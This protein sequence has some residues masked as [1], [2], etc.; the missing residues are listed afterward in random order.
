MLELSFI[1]AEE[2]KKSWKQPGSETWSIKVNIYCPLKS[3]LGIIELALRGINPLILI[4]ILHDLLST[5]IVHGN[6][7]CLPVLLWEYLLVTGSGFQI[8]AVHW[9]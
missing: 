5:I 6:V 1:A 4:F 2:P 8:L 3:E 7:C 9:K